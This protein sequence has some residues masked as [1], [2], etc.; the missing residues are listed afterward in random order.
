MEEGGKEEVEA[1]GLEGS[2]KGNPKSPNFV[3]GSLFHQNS[4]KD[5]FVCVWRTKV[6]FFFLGQKSIGFGEIY[7]F[8]FSFCR[9]LFPSGCF[10]SGKKKLDN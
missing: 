10:V 9:N 3:V 1:E 7:C 5:F 2:T 6:F 8:L 4:K